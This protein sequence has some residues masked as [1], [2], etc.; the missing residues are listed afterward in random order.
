MTSTIP[1][2]A[3]GWVREWRCPARTGLMPRHIVALHGHDC[4]YCGQETVTLSIR[5]K[6]SVP[7]TQRRYVIAEEEF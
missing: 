1:P 2:Q 6:R 5:G 3:P 7:F 4:L